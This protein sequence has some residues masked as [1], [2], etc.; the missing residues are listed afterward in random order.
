MRRV[1]VYFNLH[2]KLWSVKCLKT[3]RVIAHAKSVQLRDCKYRVS[4]RGR[5]RVLLERRKNV[6]AGIVGT[7]IALDQV[8]GYGTAFD[9][10][11]SE[12]VT[13]NPYRYETF[14]VAKDETPVY[15]TEAVYMVAQNGKA[16]V[17]AS[18]WGSIG[19]SK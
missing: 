5:E 6:H 2:R 9:F 11:T 12:I 3:G 19:V 8:A 10:D 18:I 4:K 16:T 15:Q 1:F 17:H 13:Y 7:L 14:V